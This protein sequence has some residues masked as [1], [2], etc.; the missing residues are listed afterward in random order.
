[1]QEQGYG[2]LEMVLLLHV[3]GVVVLSLL[4]RSLYHRLHAVHTRPV[5]RYEHPYPLLAA[6]QFL[7]DEDYYVLAMLL[8]VFWQLVLQYP[9]LDYDWHVSFH[10]DACILPEAHPVLFR[11][12]MSRNEFFLSAFSEQC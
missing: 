10:G 5:Q 2:R 7:Y 3:L 8:P 1:M 11:Y 4:A 9:L 12:L 6:Q